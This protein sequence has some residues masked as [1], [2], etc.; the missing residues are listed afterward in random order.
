MT[1][2]AKKTKFTL[3]INE[4]QTSVIL[5]EIDI[6]TNQQSGLKSPMQ[7]LKLQD[8]H[9]E[10]AQRHL[11]FLHFNLCMIRVVQAALLDSTV[12]PPTQL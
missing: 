9:R 10:T 11:I 3:A 2:V 5:S 6:S 8:V 12:T 1:E 7:I 4:E